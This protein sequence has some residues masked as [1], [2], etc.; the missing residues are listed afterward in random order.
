MPNR[1]CDFCSNCYKNNPD[2]GYYRVTNKI[3]SSLKLKSL[4]DPDYDF[5]CGD[6]FQPDDF[7]KGHLKAGSIQSIF[8]AVDSLFNDYSYAGKNPTS[9]EPEEDE[10]KN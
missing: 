3:R 2:V 8:P 6:H 10:S 5:I 9:V 1:T 4:I 7:E